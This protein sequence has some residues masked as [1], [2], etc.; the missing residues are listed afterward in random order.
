MKLSLYYRKDVPLLERV[1][2][3]QYIGRT[4]DHAYNDF[5]VLRGNI[6]KAWAVWQRLGNIT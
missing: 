5:L 3:F 2:Y 1:T 6:D 4:L